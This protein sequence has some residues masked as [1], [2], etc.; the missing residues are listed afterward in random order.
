MNPQNRFTITAEELERMRNQTFVWKVDLPAGVFQDQ[1]MT[2][3]DIQ[4]TVTLSRQLNL[5]ACQGDLQVRVQ[6]NHGRTLETYET[7]FPV[8]FTEG[9]EVVDYLQL[10]DK[11][12]IGLED[13]VDH[14]RVDEPIDLT[15]LIRQHIILNLPSQH[16][17]S[18]DAAA[19]CYNDPSS[20]YEPGMDQKRDPAWEAIRKTVESWEKPSQN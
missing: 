9:L 15:E 11:L 17:E 14:I 3:L 19:I 13:A 20:A 6:L 4:G 2:V 1:D 12:E 7:E 5:V 8:S 18:G 16:S 10:P